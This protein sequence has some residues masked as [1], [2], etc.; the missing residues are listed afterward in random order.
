[1]SVTNTF[2]TNNSNITRFISEMMSNS[3]EF[4]PFTA[5]EEREFIKANIN[6]PEL[7]KSELIKRNIRLV[8][9]MSKKYAL[10]TNSYDDL[11]QNGFYGLVKAAEKF[12]FKAD[13]RFCTYA[14]WWIRKYILQPYYDKYE[15][16]IKH[17]A[18]NL[19]IPVNTKDSSEKN[20][21]ISIVDTYIDPTYTRSIPDVTVETFDK[22]KCDIVD[23]ISSNIKTTDELSALDKSVYKLCMLNNHTVK[24]ASAILNTPDKEITRSKRKVNQH[25]KTFLKTQYN[26]EKYSDI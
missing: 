9:S 10:T 26:I 21:N 2:I 16:V 6:N 11:I 1:M 20:N 4:K 19:D 25:I 8:I 14:G 18:F 23:A 15:S 12:D 17:N 22:D 24:S 3:K 5:K 13:T 7:I